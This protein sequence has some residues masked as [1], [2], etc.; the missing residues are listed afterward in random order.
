MTS[1]L[2][3]TVLD[4]PTARRLWD[5]V[6]GLNVPCGHERSFRLCRG[7]ILP[8]RFLLS[9][10]KGTLG[11]R[12]E[13]TILDLCLRLDLPERVLRL[14]A[15]A[16]P[17]VGFV[18]LGFEQDRVACLYK[19]YLE[20]AMPPR[21]PTGPDPVLLHWAVK[22]NP[23]DTSRWVLTRYHWYPGLAVSDLLGR[24]ARIYDDP[25]RTEAWAIA[26]DFVLLATQ[27]VGPGGV[28]YME[29]SEE[30]NARRS[31]DLNVY[32]AGLTMGDMFP[33]LSRMAADFALPAG[34]LA[35]LLER[36][37]SRSLGHLAGG[38]HRTGEVFFNVYY[39]V[40]ECNGAVG[41]DAP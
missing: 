9:V 22:W 39:G 1:T 24:L 15:Q 38:V 36:I 23:A 27:R 30:G 26:R 16:L 37:G 31:F 2:S 12:A 6:M 4:D 25:A 19:V 7:S 5:L 21:H 3:S 29:V 11:A 33:V 8:N 17:R 28:R 14:I 41:A 32:R 34:Q 13:A 20:A 18:H 35:P 10:C 40:E